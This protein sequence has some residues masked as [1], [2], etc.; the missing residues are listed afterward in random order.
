MQ[1]IS[2]KKMNMSLSFD[3]E[4]EELPD[5]GAAAQEENENEKLLISNDDI[6]LDGL[7][8]HVINPP[9]V[10]LEPNILLDEIEILT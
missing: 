10:K 7:D 4:N 3:I 8:I 5:N 6:S 1:H 9:S 2:T